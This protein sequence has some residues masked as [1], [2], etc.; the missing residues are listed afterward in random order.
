MSPGDLAALQL[1]NGG[2]GST[3]VS[4]DGHQIDCN[5]FT[6][7]IVLRMTR[8][9]P[10]DPVMASIR[11]RAL[12]HVA[13]C[14]SS[15]V[16]G[17]F[18]FWPE[19]ARPAW[20]MSVPADADDTA[21][22]LTELLRHGWIDRRDALRRVCRAVIPHR[23]RERDTAVV[24]PWVVPGCFYT[25]IADVD[26]PNIVDCCVNANVAALM[27]RLGARALPGY[28]AA[29]LT[30]VNGMRWA[31]DD[32]R[33]LSALTPFYP[34]V[35]CLIDVVEHAIESGV[36]E[37]CDVQREL[38]ALDIDPRADGWGCCRSAYGSTVWHCVA[39]G[40]A[41]ALAD[42]AGRSRV[43]TCHAVEALGGSGSEDHRVVC[44]KS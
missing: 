29:I 12:H 5:G 2:F 4:R 15:R 22:M 30:I 37:L 19:A 27:A 6:T 11:Q 41:R 3:V 38:R 23:A 10:D 17:A 42:A 1:R 40:V 20:A 16:P 28:T 36:R 13:S 43:P 14:A 44:W 33:R 35:T 32:R 7:A 31:G 9:V 21:I 25:W 26:G 34:S 39:L 8:H 18:A 24:P